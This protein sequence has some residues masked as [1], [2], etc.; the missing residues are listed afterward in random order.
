MSV[1]NNEVSIETLDA[2]AIQTDERLPPLP[3]DWKQRPNEHDK[4]IN[5]LE[6]NNTNL[7]DICTELQTKAET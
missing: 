1:D 7:T 6:T 4:R 2:M 3:N 5:Q